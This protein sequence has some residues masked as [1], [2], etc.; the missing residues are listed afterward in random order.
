MI[1]ILLPIKT[2]AEENSGGNATGFTYETIKPD[3][4]KSQDAGY[5]DLKMTP[6]KNKPLKSNLKTWHQKRQRSQ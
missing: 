3:N 6:G 4:Q 2:Y 5:F 1:T